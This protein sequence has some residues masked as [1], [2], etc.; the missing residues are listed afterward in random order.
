MHSSAPEAITWK[1]GVACDR[2]RF[3][4]CSHQREE[5]RRKFKTWLSD[6]WQFSMI[7]MWLILIEIGWI[8]LVLVCPGAANCLLWSNKVNRPGM[9]QSTYGRRRGKSHVMSWLG[10]APTI[11]IYTPCFCTFC[12]RKRRLL[13]TEAPANSYLHLSP[14]IHLSLGDP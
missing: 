11:S 2:S 4:K 6:L 1:E 10:L 3:K 9:F 12:T 5:K 8:Q 7:K 14:Y 13:Y